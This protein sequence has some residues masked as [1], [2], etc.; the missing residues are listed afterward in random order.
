MRPNV[1]IT[2]GGIGHS[3]PTHT[4]IFRKVSIQYLLNLHL[5]YRLGIVD[6]KIIFHQADPIFS[7]GQ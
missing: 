5:L 3:L 1:R 7:A 2:K 6:G 4:Y